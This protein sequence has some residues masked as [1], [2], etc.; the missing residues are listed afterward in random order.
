M[1]NLVVNN[2][3]NDYNIGQRTYSAFSAVNFEMRHSQIKFNIV[4][5]YHLSVLIK[6]F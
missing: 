4:D 6:P 3:R 1:C 2:F 5:F